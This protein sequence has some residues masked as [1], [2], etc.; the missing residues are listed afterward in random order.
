MGIGSCLNEWSGQGLSKWREKPEDILKSEDKGYKKTY[1]ESKYTK[2]DSNKDSNSSLVVT[3]SS[4][5]ITALSVHHQ[6]E[7]LKWANHASGIHDSVPSFVMA[8]I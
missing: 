1:E 5:T 4:V 6:S 2:W 7:L 8:F 3:N